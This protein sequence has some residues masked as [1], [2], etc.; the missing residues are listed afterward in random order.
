M[1]SRMSSLMAE[2][3]TIVPPSDMDM[4]FRLDAVDS[5]YRMAYELEL[6]S[7]SAWTAIRLMDTFYA[8]TTNAT[9]QLHTPMIGAVCLD[10]AGKCVA[11][12]ENA[13][14]HPQTVV[15]MHHLLCHR[16]DDDL[17]KFRQF[18]QYVE[19]T[20]LNTLGFEVLIPT[21][22]EYLSECSR[23]FDC[24]NAA[25]GSPPRPE[26]EIKAARMT[27]YITAA[28][29]YSPQSMDF[30]AMEI[31]GFAS[32]VATTQNRAAPQSYA[33]DPP[34]LKGLWSMVAWTKGLH[35]FKVLMAFIEDISQTKPNS[36]ISRIYPEEHAFWVAH[37]TWKT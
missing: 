22:D 37:K 27:S 33:I 19:Q 25:R 21:P 1:P 4:S 18:F 5:I 12:D 10:I 7:G 24:N 35:L 30:T 15:Y 16:P 20:V 29:T 9:W 11:Y 13:C 3:Y 31:G 17:E 28:I 8:K 23:W 36:S 32:Y 14:G 26:P 34:T 6:G 2:D